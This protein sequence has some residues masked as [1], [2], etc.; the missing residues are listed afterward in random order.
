MVLAA[1]YGIFALARAGIDRGDPAA[2]LNARAVHRLEERLGLNLELTLNTWARESVAVMQA[3]GVFYRLCVLAVPVILAWLYL[4]R[5]AAY[6]RLRTHLVVLTVMDLLL[7]WLFP[8]SPP[9]FSLPGVVDYMAVHD[10]AGGAAAS[11][12][13]PGANL[14]AA[15][16]SMHVAW[17]TWCAYAVWSARSREE[18]VARPKGP[19]SA[20][21]PRWLVWLLPAATIVVVLVTGHHYVLDVVAG[22]VL[23]MVTA[24]LVRR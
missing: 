10:I 13:R 7:V 22:L 8:E 4:R 6:A 19:W 23:V 3:S 11:V 5:P 17:T 14:L 21:G 9:R 15:M 18:A 24:R 2:T 20:Y 12:P 1:S 16:P